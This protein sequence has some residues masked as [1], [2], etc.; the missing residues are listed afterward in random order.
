MYQ[1]FNGEFV[2]TTTALLIIGGA[3]LIG[4]IGGFVGNHIANQKG[5]TGW[6]K[7]GYIAGG[8]VVG[9]TAGAVGGYF[10][11][12]AVVGM[13]GVGAISVTSAGVTTI[14]AGSGTV[15][16]FGY[17]Y[18]EAVLKAG[19]SMREML[20]NT[21]QSSNLKNI[22]NSAYTKSAFTGDG[23]T[24][25]MLRHEFYNGLNS[26]HLQKANELITRLDNFILDNAGKMSFNDLFIA[27][28]LKEFI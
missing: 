19:K 11:A 13:T 16:V 2:I 14:A 20:M 21:A 22:I 27:E 8:V 4:T 9:A 10:M 1:D 6:E 15:G 24:A 25:D 5:A 18:G 28:W 7:A 12:P 26:G 23:G 3:T 17:Q